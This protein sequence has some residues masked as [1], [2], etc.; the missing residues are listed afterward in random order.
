LKTN[1]NIKLSNKLICTMPGLA[2][3]LKRPVKIN[4]AQ[5]GP[6]GALPQERSEARS[7]VLEEYIDFS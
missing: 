2:P 5:R 7:P 1:K 3:L 6:Q 4:I